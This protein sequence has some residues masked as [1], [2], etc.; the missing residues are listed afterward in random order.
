MR[1]EAAAW[2]PTRT[3]RAPETRATGPD[4]MSQ[5]QGAGGGREANSRSRSQWW[6]V[7]HASNS[8]PSPWHPSL[9]RA[10]TQKG[11]VPGPHACAPAP[12]ASGQRTP[13]ACLKGWQQAEG[14]RLS[15]DAHHEGTRRRPWE[16]CNQLV[17]PQNHVD[18]FSCLSFDFRLIYLSTLSEVSHACESGFSTDAMHKA[19]LLAWIL[20]VLNHHVPLSGSKDTLIYR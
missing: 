14:E 9:S 18:L 8:P 4:C 19:K 13:A 16:C 7:P 10:C 20:N 12:T 11:A 17:L 1:R 6:D 15:P 2:P 5:G 3:S